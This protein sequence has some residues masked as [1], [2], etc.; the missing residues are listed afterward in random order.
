MPTIKWKKLGVA[1]VSFLFALIF[2][3]AGGSKLASL[4]APMEAFLRW[5][6]PV[7]FLYVTGLV[8]VAGAVLLL[9]PAVRFY[10]AVL[11]ACTMLGAT[12]THLRAGE[13]VAVP[14]PLVLLTFAGLIAWVNRPRRRSGTTTDRGQG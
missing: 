9:I 14:V 10:G 1:S 2:F 13:M 11:L 4:D 3:Y 5:G 12:F 6:Y 8:E 7:W